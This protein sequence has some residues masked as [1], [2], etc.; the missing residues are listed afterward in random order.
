MKKLGILGGGQLGRMLIQ[1]ATDLNVE[2][3]VLDPAAD[4]PC[5]VLA[6]RFVQGS[7]LD[8]QTVFD[9]AKELDAVTIE[10]EAVNV[11]ALY[12]L[13]DAGVKVCPEP[14]AIELIQDKRKQKLFYKQ[15]GIATSDFILTDNRRQTTDLL[16]DWLPAVHKLGRGGYDGRGVQLLDQLTDAEKAFD[17]PAVLEKRV[18]IAQEI[19]VIVSRHVGGETAVFSPVASVFD[20][21]LNLV[22]YLIAPAQISKTQSQTATQLALKV[23]TE[24]DMTGLL[25]VELFLDK[26]G[27]WFVNEVAP[28]PHNSGH[29]TIEACYTSQYG[30]LLRAVLGLPA[31]STKQHTKAAMVNLLGQP[32]SN[33][34]ATYKGIEKVMGL[35]GVAV[36]LYG[37][38]DTRPGRK[39]GHVTLLQNHDMSLEEQIDFVKKNMKVMA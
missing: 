33:G 11:Q 2:T 18:D 13:Q 22:D 23:I 15:K 17:K 10:I 7:L 25:A 6:H 9:F 1:S 12:R 31:G 35:P 36:H 34:K 4:A 37:K 39:M 32:D 26:Q 29:H 27:K 5:R 21:K 19:S 14:H 16:G 8:E 24:L 28:R 30:Q 38:S 3:H 20:P